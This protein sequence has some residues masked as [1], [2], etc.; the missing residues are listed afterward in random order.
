MPDDKKPP[1]AHK[2]VFINDVLTP[3]GVLLWPK[4]AQPDTKGPYAD[5]KYKVTLAFAKDA[6][7]KALKEGILQAAKDAFGFTDLKQFAHPLRDGDK[8]AEGKPYLAGKVFLVAK[9]KVQP[10]V[11]DGSRKIL[12]PE[13]LYSGAQGRLLL[14]AFSYIGSE[15]VRDGKTGEIVTVETK[16]VTLKLEAIQFIKDGPRI[17]GTDAASKFPVA[18]ES[19]ESEGGDSLFR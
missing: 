3:E 15:K 13:A 1:A 2:A 9:C 18:G 6:D 4:V 14:T 16:G 11:F 5:G 7:F 10:Q 19:V 12:S 17:G 8:K